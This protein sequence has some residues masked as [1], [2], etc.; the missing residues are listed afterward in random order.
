MDIQSIV[1][2]AHDVA[3]DF[4]ATRDERQRRTEADPEDFQRLQ[5]IGYHLMAAPKDLGG[6][7]ESYSQSARPICTVIRTIAKGDPSVALASAMHHLVLAAWRPQEAP[8]PFTADF[9]KQRREVFGTVHEGAWWGTIVSEPGSGGDTAKTRATASPTGDPHRYL[10]NGAKHFGSGSGVTSFMTTRARPADEDGMDNFFL[11]VRGVPWDGSTG[12]KL[13][14]PWAGHGMMSTNSHAFHFTDFPATRCAWPAYD[15]EK[16]APDNG[17]LG[18]GAFLSSVVG[19]VD[20]AMEY[21]RQRM[22]GALSSDSG[23]RAFQ[24]VE[25]SYA[26][27]DAWLINQAF[28]G[29]MQA[30]ENGSQTRYTALI[31]KESIARLA[32]S[33]LDRLC[34]ISGGTAYTWHSPL[35]AWRQDV[36]ALGYLRPPWPL[37]FDQLF[38]L[39]W[40]GA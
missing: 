9:S 32:E 14:A 15:R 35:G 7:W 3:R 29:A 33:V 24:K 4:A 1:D 22:E 34:K 31:A 37:A 25:W 6:A 36:H 11:E 26:E 19:V 40:E 23:L 18:A 13:T 16:A 21:A 10:L 39:S 28:E 17:G 38:E 12:M 27:Q 5:E 2:K 30:A 20:A 8:E